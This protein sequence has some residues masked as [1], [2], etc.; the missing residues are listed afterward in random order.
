MFH[1]KINQ[2][3]GGIIITWLIYRTVLLTRQPYVLDGSVSRYLYIILVLIAMTQLAILYMLIRDW[4]KVNR[5]PN[6]LIRVVLRILEEIYYK[7]LEHIGR[8]LL[9][10]KLVVRITV[11]WSKVLLAYVNTK[12]RIFLLTILLQLNP[13]IIILIGLLV[14]VF[15]LGKILIFY[16]VIWYGIIPLIYMGILGLIK[17]ETQKRM[18]K[19]LAE[20]IAVEDDIDQIRIKPLP[21]RNDMTQEDL[22]RYKEAWVDMTNILDITKAITLITKER[23]YVG[24]MIVIT[25]LFLICWTACILK[26]TLGYIRLCIPSVVYAILHIIFGL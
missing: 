23:L 18:D 14:D 26:I 8:S 11:Y 12:R 21:E 15:I 1:P 10:R 2:V 7:P 16:K 9:Q 3:I 5:K 19:L 24:I 4:R 17:I 13:K 20:E 6:L 25:L 22:E